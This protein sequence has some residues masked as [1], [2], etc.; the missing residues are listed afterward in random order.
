MVRDMITVRADIM[1]N[2]IRM[3]MKCKSQ[4]RERKANKKEIDKLSVHQ[5]IKIE[6]F[7]VKKYLSE[8]KK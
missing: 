7:P 8:S 3:V 2:S 6:L 1:G 5:P 4:N